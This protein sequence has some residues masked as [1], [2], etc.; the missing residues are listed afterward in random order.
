MEEAQ[1]EFES[2]ESQTEEPAVTPE[3]PEVPETP[4][5]EE[6]SEPELILGKFKDQDT[7]AKS[8]QELERRIGQ[9]DELAALGQAM[10]DHEAEFMEFLQ[11]KQQKAEPEIKPGPPEE[12]I[13]EYDPAWAEMTA[14]EMTPQDKAKLAKY[15]R[16]FINQ[17]RELVHNSQL[18]ELLRDP[19]GYLTKTV[20]PVIGGLQKTAT[21]LQAERQTEILA[22][23]VQATLDP[24]AKELFRDG[25][26]DWQ[27]TTE[28]GTKVA[29]IWQSDP[30]FA[31]AN[32]VSWLQKSIRLAKAEMPKPNEVRKPAA[33]AKRQAAVAPPPSDAVNLQAEAEKLAKEGWS[34]AAIQT[35]LMKKFY[36][37]TE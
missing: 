29:E 28:L 34:M 17:T 32:P 10:V 18:R 16:W 30:E 25:K 22:T 26:I 27:N 15:N 1:T 21:E 5:T 4:E 23:K 11:S 12:K 37:A 35:H 19:Q 9:R 6:S 7:L 13:P 20:Q 31:K 36:G 33:A 24:V 14:E 8:Y 3:T 2:K